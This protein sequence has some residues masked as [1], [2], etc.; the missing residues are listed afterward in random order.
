MPALK[1][2]HVGKGALAS[3]LRSSNMR[4]AHCERKMSDFAGGYSKLNG[5]PLCH[6]HASG[7]PDCYKLVSFYNH[8]MPCEKKVCYESHNNLMD[9]VDGK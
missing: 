5:K 7:R 2:K 6:P 1:Q 3:S 9:Y 8:T 4:C